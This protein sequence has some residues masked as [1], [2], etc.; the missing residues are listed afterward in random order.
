AAAMASRFCAALA[1]ADADG[2]LKNFL[3]KSRAELVELNG[4]AAR[5]GAV[6]EDWIA[7]SRALC[8]VGDELAAA[9]GDMANWSVAPERFTLRLAK[10]LQAM[11]GKTAETL[12]SFGP[13]AQS[14]LAQAKADGMELQAVFRRARGAALESE[15]AVESLK[16]R[17]VFRRLSEAGAA[18]DKAVEGLAWIL[19][20]GE[21]GGGRAH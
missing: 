6:G 8:R 3:D 13:M 9:A 5:A 7:V 10:L 15:R 18:A 20:E 11:L 19:A 14:G 21:R 1:S 16:L 17:E 2:G 12:A 4:G